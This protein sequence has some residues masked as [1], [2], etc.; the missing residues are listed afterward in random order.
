MS[1]C[2]GNPISIRILHF[3]RENLLATEGEFIGRIMFLKRHEK[4]WKNSSI[5]CLVYSKSVSHVPFET[6]ENS[7]SLVMFA[8]LHTFHPNNNNSSVTVLSK[9]CEKKNGEKCSSGR[10]KRKTSER[11]LW[12]AHATRVGVWLITTSLGWVEKEKCICMTLGKRQEKWIF[13]SVKCNWTNC[14][15]CNFSR[16]ELVK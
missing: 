15:C 13:I 7:P 2:V 1:F 14:C 6:N 16:E 11:K 9:K 10:I 3:R 12:T 5:Y 4:L 8:S